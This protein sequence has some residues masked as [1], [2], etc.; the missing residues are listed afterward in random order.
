MHDVSV[1]GAPL[2]ETPDPL[3]RREH[4]TPGFRTHPARVSTFHA[5]K[6]RSDLSEPD[7]LRRPISRLRKECI[8]AGAPGFIRQPFVILVGHVRDGLHL[9]LGHGEEEAVA[10][11]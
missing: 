9:C 7:P 5:I 8:V 1:A 10:L 11:L 2:R 6:T 4:Y 3:G